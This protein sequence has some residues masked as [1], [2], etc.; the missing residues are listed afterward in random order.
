MPPDAVRDLCRV[1]M[2]E[3]FAGPSRS[4][5]VDLM[6]RGTFYSKTSADRFV[7]VVAN[8]RLFAKQ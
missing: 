4:T 3:D 5:A 1:G 6:G 7:D 2:V 8:H